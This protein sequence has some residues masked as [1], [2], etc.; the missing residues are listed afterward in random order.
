MK[1]LKRAFLLLLSCLFASTI[2]LA[3]CSSKDSGG[4]GGD[5]TST[6]TSSGSSSSSSSGSGSSEEEPITFADGTMLESISLNTAGAKT[7]YSVGETFSSDGLVVTATTSL[8]FITSSTIITSGYTVDSSGFDG[9]KAGTY[10][11]YVSYAIPNNTAAIQYASYSVTVSSGLPAYAN[12]DITYSGTKQYNLTS[13]GVSIDLSSSLITVTSYIGE[14]SSDITTDTV[15]DYELYYSVNGGELTAVTGS[16]ITATE[17][18]TYSVY[19]VKDYVSGTETFG[20]KA[21]FII[22]IIDV[23]TGIV[24][25]NDGTTSFSYGARNFGSDW[26]YTVTYNSGATKTKSYSD[27]KITADNTASGKATVSFTNTYVGLD[28]NGEATEISDTAVTTTVAYTVASAT[29]GDTAGF[30]YGSVSDT[31]SFSST[32]YSAGTAIETNDAFSL[33]S[34]AATLTSLGTGSKTI[35]SIDN[36]SF[37]FTDMDSTSVSPDYGLKMSSNINA[38]EDSGA[39]FTLTAKVNCTVQLYLT[40]ANDS[41][42]SHRAGSIYYQVEDEDAVSTSVSSRTTVVTVKVVL[43]EGE[44]LTIGVVNN[45]TSTAKLWLFGAQAKQIQSTD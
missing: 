24:W 11:I 27:V 42:N 14:N 29:L 28:S 12:M 31:S 6:N 19:A 15:T 13:E 8:N 2:A 4:S 23:A 36:S 32:S 18:G 44:T 21:Q 25:N 30:T 17:A 9:S 5:S 35:Q 1:K 3:A 10:T 34:T 41:Y 45:A 38:G 33:V 39:V 37:S 7:S 20:M 16:S 26:T 43:Y 40:F 22:Y